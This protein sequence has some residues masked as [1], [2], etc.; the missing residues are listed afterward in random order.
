MVSAASKRIV[1]HKIKS[2]H[3]YSQKHFMPILY[4]VATRTHTGKVRDHN[5][6]AVGA[7]LDWRERLALDD[8]LLQQ[9]GH[10]FAVADGMGGHA[11]GEV[12][13]ALA[14]ETLFTEYYTGPWQGD[15]ETMLTAAV[16]AAN[17][18]VWE[19][20]E[21]NAAQHGMGTT[22]VALVHQ[23]G[24]ELVAN[25]GDSRAYRFRAGKISQVTTD[26]SWVAE[27]MQNGVL[28]ESEA[29]KHPLRNVITRSLGSEPEVTPDLFVDEAQPGDI[30][31]LCSDGL[32]NVVKPKEMA[33]ILQAYPLDEAADKLV[34]LTLERGAPD[35]VSLVLVQVQ[36]KAQRRSKS[37]LP[38]LALVVA[39]A[40]LG[41]FLYRT[42]AP[43]RGEQPPVVA[44]PVV[45]LATLT[46]EATP[47]RL[48][49][50]PAATPTSAG[51]MAAGSGA[52]VGLG[53]RT[54]R[55]ISGAGHFTP[56]SENENIEQLQIDSA[57]QGTVVADLDTGHYVH[58][59][60]KDAPE[61]ILVGYEI[62]GQAG[63]LQPVLVLAPKSDT[64]LLIVWQADD[65]AAQYYL[66][67]LHPDGRVDA[68][69]GLIL[70][71]R[72]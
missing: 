49:P 47:A 19:A 29:A 56:A 44:S 55:E 43:I 6:D 38:W 10:L 57:E 63:V 16:Q 54:L 2:P 53:D 20:S 8:E 25:V 31:L 13:S 15:A 22:L 45:L 3:L 60:D 21:N 11:A 42:F 46:P 66:G 17:R 69:S 18:A 62:Q 14:M 61:L 27:Q 71:E 30:M 41:F 35:N 52:S 37:F 36:G 72:Q 65:E 70:L 4:Q 28:S 9:R 68:E 51:L 12:A 59:E 24:V 40:A 48:T 67:M 64:E 39:L 7:V 5:E 26:H 58:T 32:S 33:N 1:T 34:E 23:P 50:A